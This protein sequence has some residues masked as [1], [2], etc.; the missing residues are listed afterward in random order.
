MNIGFQMNTV[1][2]PGFPRLMTAHS[3]HQQL[4]L[5]PSEKSF[6]LE[7]AVFS[8]QAITDGELGLA[9]A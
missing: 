2:L 1:C 7:R 6:A 8:F 9:P 5:K 4:A 3:I